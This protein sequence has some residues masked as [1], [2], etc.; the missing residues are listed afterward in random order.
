[1]LKD[2]VNS[3]GFFVEQLTLQ[4]SKI[5]SIIKIIVEVD[6]KDGMVG[7]MEIESRVETK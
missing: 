2:I 7:Y 3:I 5:Y 4:N 1:V 6:L